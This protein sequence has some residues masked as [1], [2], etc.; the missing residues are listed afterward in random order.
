MEGS[1]RTSLSKPWHPAKLSN[2]YNCISGTAETGAPSPPRPSTT[3]GALPRRRPAA[4]GGHRRPPRK[5][6][7]QRAGE[8]ALPGPCGV[9]AGFRPAGTPERHIQGTDE[10]CEGKAAAEPCP[11]SHSRCDP[12]A[13]GRWVAVTFGTVSIGG[14]PAEPARPAALPLT[15]AML[16]R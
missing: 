1:L 13:Y 11:S 2:W 16:L 9:R 7:P 10:G 4:P 6:Q 12:L 15:L 14:T 5:T 8:A 3:R